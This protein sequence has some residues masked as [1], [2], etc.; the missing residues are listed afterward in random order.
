MS[1]DHAE[2]DSPTR[3]FLKGKINVSLRNKIF[4]CSLDVSLVKF[5]KFPT[6]K[7][8]EKENRNKKQKYAN[9]NKHCDEQR[10]LRNLLG[11]YAMKLLKHIKYF[12][13]ST[14]GTQRVGWM[15]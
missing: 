11:V 10:Q 14:V 2:L 3:K 6:T 5:L 9:V 15:L 7:K 8:P 13:R 12:K 4:A 1:F